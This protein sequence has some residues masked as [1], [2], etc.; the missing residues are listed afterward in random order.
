M[1]SIVPA[2]HAGE[3]EPTGADSPNRRAAEWNLLYQPGADVWVTDPAGELVLRTRTR[4]WAS[5][6]NGTALVEV[7]GLKQRV[8]L[9]QVLPADTRT[10][11]EKARDAW[12]LAHG[13]G[14][15]VYAWPGARPEG[16]RLT[17]ATRSPAWVVGG[18]TACVMVDRCPGG[19]ALTHIEVRD[20]R[21]PA[22]AS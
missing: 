7:N 10:P 17:T 13:I 6:D 11:A 4:S 3:P 21:T 20:A 22:G 1:T 18:H 2:P 15:E 16:R 14:T 12:N 5:V 8:R 19:I 9:D